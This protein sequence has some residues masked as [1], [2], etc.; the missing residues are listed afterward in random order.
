MRKLIG[1]FLLR[2]CEPFFAAGFLG[3][4]FEGVPL[5]SPPLCKGRWQARNEPDGGVVTHKKI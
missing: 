4:L 3:A 5:F 2:K 1:L